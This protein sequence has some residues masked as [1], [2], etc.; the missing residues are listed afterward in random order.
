MRKHF[1]YLLTVTA[2][3]FSCTFPD[4]PQSQWTFIVYTGN[5]S[6]PNPLNNIQ[7]DIEEMIQSGV[8]LSSMRVLLFNDYKEQGDTRLAVLD[9]VLDSDFRDIPLSA[10]GIPLIG[11]NE[12][13]CSDPAVLDAVIQYAQQ[14]LPAENY[15]LFTGAHGAGYGYGQSPG[16]N[17]EGYTITPVEDI[18]AVLSDKNIDVFFMDNCIMGTIEVIY[19]LRNCADYIVTSPAQIPGPG[20][21][22]ADLFRELSQNLYNTEDFLREALNS[23]YRAYEGSDPPGY[24]RPAGLVSTQELLMAYKTANLERIVKESLNEDLKAFNDS[25]RSLN[26]TGVLTYA[27]DANLTNWDYT[28][29]FD[30][31]NKNMGGTFLSEINREIIR[32]DGALRNYISIYL[33][34]YW[35]LTSWYRNE[36]NGNINSFATD[37]PEWIRLLDTHHGL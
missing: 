18:A 34:S 2:L 23:Y 21:N 16:L 28:D 17:M 5:D 24:V 1:F 15:A 25:G 13:D 22:Y 26:T 19:E 31:I 4:Y 9:S 29:L 32:P 37:C 6:Q 8:D 10:A 27:T 7:L 12:A 36:V 11:R 35:S 3:I 33:P 20:H 14:H 30:L